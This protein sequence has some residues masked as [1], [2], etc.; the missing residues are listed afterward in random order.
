MATTASAA[1][2]ERIAEVLRQSACSTSLPAAWAAVPALFA[3]RCHSGLIQ[4]FFIWSPRPGSLSLPPWMSRRAFFTFT[5][6]YCV[7]AE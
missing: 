3:R 6:L 7:I 4:P 1:S 2:A 5:A